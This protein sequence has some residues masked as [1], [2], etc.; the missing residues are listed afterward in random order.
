MRFETTLP[1]G[2]F[3]DILIALALPKFEAGFNDLLTNWE[4]AIL[5]QSESNA[6]A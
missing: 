1:G 4:Q 2:Y 5:A 3:G 6:A